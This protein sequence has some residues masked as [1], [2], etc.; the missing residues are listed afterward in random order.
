M[1]RV[2]LAVT[3][4]LLSL[5]LLAPPAAA[6]EQQGNDPANDVPYDRGDIT[7]YRAIHT[8]SKLILNVRTAQ[9]GRPEN[10][11]PNRQTYIRWNIDTDFGQAGPEYYADLRIGTGV[12]TVLIGRVRR[13]S[14]N[15]LMC[16]AQRNVPGDNTISSAQNLYRFAFLRG[17]VGAPTELRAR[18]TFRWDQGN[19]G[20]GPVYTDYAPN[21]GPTQPLSAG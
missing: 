1:R 8:S 2:L 19:P 7:F 17:C 18:A 15:Q 14:N 16:S 9:G 10:V 13:A 3:A 21:G 11:W 6:E 4:G 5:V 12:D 20:V